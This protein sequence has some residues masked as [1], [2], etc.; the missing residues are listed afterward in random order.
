MTLEFNRREVLQASLAGAVS[1]A[2]PAMG[3]SI[4][5]LSPSN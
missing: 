1:I 2:M 3:K 4:F 5:P